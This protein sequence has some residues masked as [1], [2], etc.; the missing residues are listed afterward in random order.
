MKDQEAKIKKSYHESINLIEKQYKGWIKINA[1]AL[2][3]LAFKNHI[4]ERFNKADSKKQL[5]KM[6]SERKQRLAL[7]WEQYEK[8]IHD[9][10]EV[11]FRIPSRV[12]MISRT[13]KIT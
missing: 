5:K 13:T 3:F 8:T 10:K 9:L 6:K 12:L 7:M 2:F 4:L 11:S 1:A